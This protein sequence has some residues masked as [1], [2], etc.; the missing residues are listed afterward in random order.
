MGQRLFLTY[1]AQCHG[2]DAGGS[3]GF[4]N[5]RDTDWLYGGE[6]EAIRASIMEGR[7]GV[8]PTCEAR[9]SPETIK[10]LAVYVH[11]NSAGDSYVPPPAVASTGL[12]A[13]SRGLRSSAP[14]VRPI[15][16]VR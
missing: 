2:S 11:A 10:A 13:L 16:A 9:F 14:A 7:N 15:T 8:M 3:R 4:P 12:S 5:L 6:P 1:C